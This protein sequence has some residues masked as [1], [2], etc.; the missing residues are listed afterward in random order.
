MRLKKL[1]LLLKNLVKLKNIVSI[2]MSVQSDLLTN[3]QN[4]FQNT[5]AKA[6][7]PASMVGG[8]KEK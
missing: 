2:Y 1:I 5:A 8:K 6:G 7:C 4:T 3:T